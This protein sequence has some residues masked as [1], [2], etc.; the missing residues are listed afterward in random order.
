MFKAVLAA[1]V[2][3]T[4]GFAPVKAHANAIG[5]TVNLTYYYPNASTTYYNSTTV[6]NTSST[7]EFTINGTTFNF[8]TVDITATQIITTFLNTGQFTPSG[9]LVGYYLSDLTKAFNSISLDASTTSAPPTGINLIG[10]G[11]LQINFSGMNVVAGQKYVLNYTNAAAAVTPEP[12]SLLLLGTGLLGVVGA[13][14]RRFMT[15]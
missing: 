12:S 10:N 13:A 1:L 3:A 2:V 4:V 7:P 5:D 6:A 11:T 14:R 8:M 9:S 15:A